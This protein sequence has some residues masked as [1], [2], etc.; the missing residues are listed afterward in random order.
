MADQD[1]YELLDA[2]IDGKAGVLEDPE[3]AVLAVIA[4]DLRG[5]PHPGFKRELKG[6]ILP[7]NLEMTTTTEVRKPAG[8]GTVTPYLV[9]KDIA[10]LHAFLRD[11]FGAEI[12]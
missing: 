4:S 10:R 5:L 9:G 12:L 8:F 1:R 7:M 3:L 6:R 11:A 2:M